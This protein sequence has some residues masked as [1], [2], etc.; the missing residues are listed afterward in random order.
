MFA[1]VRWWQWLLVV[2]AAYVLISAIMYLPSMVQGFA[3]GFN[4]GR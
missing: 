3:D 1:K 4:A 2:A